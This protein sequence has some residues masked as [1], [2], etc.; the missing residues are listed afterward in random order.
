MLRAFLKDSAVYAVPAFLSRGLALLLVPL[1]T[2]V[3]SP[4]DYGSLDLLIVFAGIINLTISLEVSQGVARFY[5]GEEDSSRKVAYASSAFWFTLGCYSFF[6][7]ILLAFTNPL[8]H[9]VMGQ[10][11]LEAAFQIGI[12]Y[13]WVNGV[14]YLIQNQF[15]WELRPK[16]YAVVSLV[17]SFVT[18]GVSVW[19]AYGLLWGLEGLLIGMVVGSGFGAALGLSWLRKSFRFRFDGARLREMLV[20]SSPLVFS[21]IAVWISLYIDRIMINHFLSIDEVGLYGIG[22]RVASIAGIAMVG[23]QGALT[24]LVYTYYRDH[25]TPRQLARI[26]RLFLVLALT[27][28]L[29]LSLFASDVLRLLTTESFYGGAVVVVYLVPAILL[30]NMY[31]FAPGIAIAKKTHYFIWINTGGALL[32]IV[33]NYLL[34]P[35]LGIVGAG[36]ATLVGY[37]VVFSLYM[38]A[39]QRLYRV[40]HHWYPIV[41]AVLVA[42]GL[43]WLLPQLPMADGLRWGVNVLALAVFASIAVFVGLL[44]P[45]E[46]RQ[47]MT[48]LRARFRAG[49]LSP[50]Y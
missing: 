35:V 2:R 29:G 15:R 20:F 21:G 46:V 9:W 40:P 32:N 47:G 6:A 10:P 31:I 49:S 17:M 27:V 36:L 4:A 43:A 37:L 41:V 23:F 45:D 13:I 16:P 24:P 50:R 11:D 8:A 38:A 25:D 30:A 19:L 1:Y 12:V 7:V 42:A 26:F 5:A 48:G 34:I 18:G 39:S 22:H 28:F 3:L 14:F 44:H 33:L